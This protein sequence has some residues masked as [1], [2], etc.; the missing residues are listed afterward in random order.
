MN[1]KLSTALSSAQFVDN[2]YM[3]FSGEPSTRVFPNMSF[4]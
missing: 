3:G 4:I 2:V 1:I